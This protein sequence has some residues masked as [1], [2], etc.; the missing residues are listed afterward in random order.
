MATND[1]YRVNKDTSARKN[2]PG[3][4]MVHSDIRL[5]AK[6]AGEE[7]QRQ[8]Y[9][10]AFEAG[11]E[12]QIVQ[13]KAECSEQIEALKVSHSMANAEY[14]ASF[15]AERA[16]FETEKKS[17]EA[18]KK[19][20]EAATDKIEKDKVAS[21]KEAVAKVKGDLQKAIK[22][23]TDERAKHAAEKAE[24]DAEQ[25]RANS[26]FTDMEAHVQAAWAEHAKRMTELENKHEGDIKSLN[27]KHNS[28]VAELKKQ[29]LIGPNSWVPVRIKG[30]SLKERSFHARYSTTF[31][32]VVYDFYQLLPKSY[33]GDFSLNGEVIKNHNRTLEQIGLIEGH[34]I[35]FDQGMAKEETKGYIPSSKHTLGGFPGPQTDQKQP[36]RTSAFV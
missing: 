22:L 5:A 12:A 1:H 33:Y 21:N 17:F 11:C 23:L 34:V 9:L 27:R 26:K 14:K 30:R 4:G 10:A 13:A 35:E 32:Q 15:E 8:A 2:S 28:Q 16:G 6:A 7:A 20:F 36:A 25:T 3:L 29:L 24:L 18:E 31:K 19:K